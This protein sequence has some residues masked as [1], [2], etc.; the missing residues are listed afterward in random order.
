MSQTA[1]APHS[2]T[3]WFSIPA[4]D[5]DRAVRFYETILESKLHV[6]PF[7]ADTIGVF[8]H[9]SV[10]GI[11]GCVAKGGTPSTDGVL[12]YLNVDGRL[13]RTLANVKDA[14]GRITA[15]KVELPEGQGFVAEIVD[16][17]GNRVGLHAKA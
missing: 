9:D 5:F 12:L 8:A 10:D 1:H 2:A 17:E 16:S 3:S 15:A 4:R 7:G 14:G 11:G 13:D 6:H